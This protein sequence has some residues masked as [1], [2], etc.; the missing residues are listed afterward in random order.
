[1]RDKC[2]RKAGR[3]LK[4]SKCDRPGNQF[5]KWFI[6]SEDQ[7]IRWANNAL[8]TI[9]VHAKFA[10]SALTARKVAPVQL[11][12]VVN[13]SARSNEKWNVVYDSPPTPSPTSSPSMYYSDKDDDDDGDIVIQFLTDMSMQCLDDE[14]SLTDALTSR[15]PFNMLQN[16]CDSNQ[17]PLFEKGLETYEQCSGASILE[18]IQS[19]GSA[20][21]GGAMTCLPYLYDNYFSNDDDFFEQSAPTFPLPRI[22]QQCVDSFLGDNSVG[23]FMRN[24]L[25]MTK[26]GMTCLA[27][28]G[29][30]VPD[31]TLYRWPVPI[32]GPLLKVASCAYPMFEDIFSMS[33]EDELSVLSQCLPSVSEMENATDEMCYKWIDQCAQKDMEFGPVPFFGMSLPPPLTARPLNDICHDPSLDGEV[34][35][36]YE[37]FRDECIPEKDKKIWEKMSMSV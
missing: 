30:S 29:Q 20:V 15:N 36:R 19:I 33:C 21:F 4:F 12:N 14:S 18:F 22:P 16:Y 23:N 10:T 31:C 27:E 2:I 13:R 3:Y 5:L 1:M 11:G 28:L 35:K 25:T 37:F 34:S 24:E 17:M 6:L 8:M 9:R 26:N 7:T 32:V